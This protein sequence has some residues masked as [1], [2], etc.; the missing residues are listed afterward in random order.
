ML[1]APVK[2]DPAVC[3]GESGAVGMG[4]VS[5]IMEDDGYKDLHDD[6][7]GRVGGEAVGEVAH[8]SPGQGPHPGL[9]EHVGGPQ[10]RPGGG[11]GGQQAGP[12]GGGPHAQGQR[13]VP[14]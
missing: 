12:E 8:H 9:D 5:A 11:L 13:Q 4:V 14:V 10:P 1:A 6:K 2:G 7:L 3:S